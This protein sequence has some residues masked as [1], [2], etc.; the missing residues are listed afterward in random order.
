M[1]EGILQATEEVVGG[2]AVDGLAV[3]L[4]GVAQDDP[5]NVGPASFAIGSDDWRAGAEVDLGLVAGVALDAAE[6]EVVHLL[7]ASDEATHAVVA[8]CEA[9]VGDQVLID[10]LCGESEA[11]LG[12]DQVPPG[13]TTADSTAAAGLGSGCRTGGHIDGLGLVFVRL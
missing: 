9:V 5:E 1:A 10:P 12:S 8:A 3:S 2:L 4:A 6:G 13:L 7:E 11:A